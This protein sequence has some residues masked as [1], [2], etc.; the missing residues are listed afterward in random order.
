MNGSAAIAD[1]VDL[2]IVG[3]GIAGLVAARRAAELGA[4]VLV[5]EG[6]ADTGGMLQ[7]ARIAQ[8]SIDI[9]AEGFA[10]RGGVVADYLRGLGLDEL[11]VAPNALGSWGYAAGSAYR[12]PNAGVLG[13]PADPASAQV[14]AAI[15]AAGAARAEQESRLPLQALPAS[16]AELV[17]ERL[18]ETVLE[19]L[20]APV[21]RGVYSADPET[22]DPR[23]LV[24]G[25]AD[26]IARTG[27]LTAAVRQLREAAPPGAAL[28]GLRGGMWQFVRELHREAQRLGVRVATGRRVRAL[29]SKARGFELQLEREVLAS[30]RVLLTVPPGARLHAEPFDRILAGPAAADIPVEV[31]ALHLDAPALDQAPRGTGVLVAD[32]AGDVQAKALTHATAKWSWLAQ[33]AGAGRHLVRLSYGAADAHPAEPRSRGLDRE[34]LAQLALRDAALLLGVPLAAGQLLQLERREWRIPAPAARIG[35]AEQLAAARKAVAAVAGLE[36]AGTWVDGTG[37]ATVIPGAVR[38]AERLIEG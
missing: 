33:A 12:L 34:R 30:P 4:R 21:A 28:N 18:G 13:I 1:G 6:G 36:L 23:I 29:R 11:I 8:L 24:P 32:A 22:L 37:L 19:R 14:V 27:S 26:R 15:G 17:R 7:P 31:V 25:L 2:I 10:T 38:A 3:A 9:G 20:V 5:L 35:R 16:L